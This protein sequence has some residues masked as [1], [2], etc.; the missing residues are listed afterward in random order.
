MY[1]L[2]AQVTGSTSGGGLGAAIGVLIWVVVVVAL[3]AGIWKLF[4]KAG[5]PGWQR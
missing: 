3:L 2:F 4:A 1:T 5:Q